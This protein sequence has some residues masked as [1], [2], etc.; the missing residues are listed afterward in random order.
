M[1][2]FRHIRDKHF[3]ERLCYIFIG[4]IALLSFTAL[5]LCSCACQTNQMYCP[6]PF[7]MAAK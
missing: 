5:I 1:I 6:P 4:M 7:D 3:V 2:V